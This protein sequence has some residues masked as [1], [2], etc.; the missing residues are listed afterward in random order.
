MASITI[1]RDIRLVLDGAALPGVTKVMHLVMDD[2]QAVIGFMPRLLNTSMPDSSQSVDAVLC[3]TVGC[4]RTLL[5]RLIGGGCICGNDINNL[6]GRRES[7]IFRVVDDPLPGVRHGLIVIGSD[8]R[9]TIYGLFHLSEL[10]GVSPL[11]NWSGIQPAHRETVVLN[12]TVNMTSK[13]PSVTYRGFFINDEWPAFGNWSRIH[14]GGANKDC[15]MKI[16]ELL[17]RLKGNYL[18]P[19]M[20]V[21]N[22]S[23]D[24]PDLQSAQ[25]ADEL[26][27]V[28]STSHHEPCMR[29]GE[30]YSMVRGPG[31]KYGDAW[32]YRTNSEGITRFWRDGLKRNRAFENVY[33]MG[34]RGER[35][36]AIMKN[37]SREDNIQLLQDV[38]A[39]QNRLIREVINPDLNAVA[40]QIVLFN[41]VEGFFFPPNGDEERN[42]LIDDK[43][44]D[45]VTIVL[46]DNN[47]GYT[48]ILPDARARTHNGGFGMYY[49]MDMHGGPTSYEWVGSTYLPRVWDQ[50][51]TAYDYGVRQIWV[52][53]VGDIATNELA[54]SY[55]LDMAYD[56]DRYGSSNPNNTTDYMVRWIST[57]FSG[58]F[59]SADLETIHEILERYLLMCERRK[60][61]VMGENVYHPTHYGEAQ[62]LLE[63]CDWV[64]QEC[65][66]LRDLCPKWVFPGFM[67]LVW[68]PAMATA[69]LMK[70]WILAGR[71]NLY[72][73]QNRVDANLLADQVKL[74][75][76]QD[77]D[78]IEEF[79]TVDG[80][81]F[82]GFGLSEHFGFRHWCADDNQYP[83]R[84]YIEPANLPR[85][86]VSVGDAE[87]YSIGSRW[88]GDQ[89]EIKD[90]ADPRVNS[91]TM[92]ISCASRSAVRFAIESDCRW[93][94]FSKYQGI[95]SR[96][97]DIIIS[98]DRNASIDAAPC[99]FHVTALA[100]GQRVLSPERGPSNVCVTA[101]APDRWTPIPGEDILRT[102]H[103]VGGVVVIE[104][105][106]YANANEGEDGSAFIRIAPYG[107]SGAAMKVLP[108]TADHRALKLPAAAPWLEYRFVVQ[109][110][111]EYD[112]MWVMAPTMPVTAEQ[113]LCIGTQTND[114]EIHIDDTVWDKSGVF[115]MGPE[116]SREGT[117]NVKYFRTKISCVKGRNSLRFY[118]VSANVVLER[119]VVARDLAALPESYLGPRESPLY[120]QYGQRRVQPIT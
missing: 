57:Q 48:R 22:F 30:E 68:Y 46:S 83:V 85:L 96:Y 6:S 87:Q 14:F 5:T 36:T 52:T 35:D 105:D 109:E 16:F 91:V 108:T 99:R 23:V 1:D 111:G 58:A 61:E 13:E 88:V 72:A 41:E 49:H 47:I 21:D 44:L 93:L 67:E 45:G 110:T 24:G 120:D 18:W 60:H 56:I 17:L 9:G 20:W 64:M 73:R 43:E 4:D 19:A 11:R 65:S 54:L 38:L 92:R 80:G 98:L 116:Y 40:R 70:T 100:D 26:G 33:T 103:E 84:R 32:N 29:S 112:L 97:E 62:E 28:M 10:L 34:M 86:V 78:I 74:G 63:S 71:N 90:F 82:D 76:D 114:G 2:I 104:A 37:A 8:K 113:N 81:R 39:E 53:N 101:Y 42:S 79:H 3:G 69:N 89:L 95:V 12:D 25:L 107:R 31:S 77:R 51:S 50:M 55:F 94:R 117:D 75:I 119:V 59:V 66:R 118:H 115:Y 27:V 102:Y 106:H 15:Y 7:Y